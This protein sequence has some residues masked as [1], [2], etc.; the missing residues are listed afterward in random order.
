MTFFPL[1]SFLPLNNTFLFYRDQGTGHM[2]AHLSKQW[3]W[4]ICWHNEKHWFLSSLLWFH[5]MHRIPLKT[6]PGSLQGNA[7]PGQCLARLP[8]LWAFAKKQP[9]F[10]DPGLSDQNQAW[11]P[12][13]ET[14]HN[15]APD[16]SIFKIQPVLFT[17]WSRALSDGRWLLY[18]IY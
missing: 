3:D 13:L 1:Q 12:D 9:M 11:P 2:A 4:L 18:L 8:P 10:G 7:V 15:S 17:K 14:S 6:H 16:S 5:N